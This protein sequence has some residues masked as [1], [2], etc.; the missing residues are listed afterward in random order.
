MGFLTDWITDWL[1]ET[2]IDG[3]MGNLSGIFDGVNGRVGEIAEQ[4][5]TS[6]ADWNA[7]VFSLIRELSETV[8]LPIAGLILTYIA[9]MELIHMIIDRNNLQE[10]ETW[11]F[12]KWC[13]KTAAAILILS[14]TFN[15]VMAVFDVAQRLINDA[16]GVIQGS[17]DVT[18]DMMDALQTQLE[19]MNIG[20]LLG[21]WMQTLLINLTM[22]ALN[23]AIFVVIWGRMMEIYMRV[24]LA[25]IP[26]ATLTSR[27]QGQ[28][29]QGYLKSLFAVGFQGML[30]L[31]CVAIYAILI[32]GIATSGDPIGAIWTV[33]G[34]TVLLVFTLFKTGSIAKSILGTS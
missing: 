16:G 3:I 25:P 11:M 20:P 18:P 17:T 27:E 32:Q 23:I 22:L 26:M 7:G 1:K 24:S 10:I 9:T 31:V 19:A 30:I 15:I 4:V 28:M 8:V 6:P 21:L 13:F 5:G 14:N 12:Y 33:V 29:G 2:L 34:Y